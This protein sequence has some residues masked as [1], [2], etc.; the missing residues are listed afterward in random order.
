MYGQGSYFARDAATSLNWT[1]GS[2]LIIV[3]RVLV[4]DSALGTFNCVMPP[5]RDPSNPLGERFDSCVDFLSNPSIFV[6]FEFGQSY[7]AYII[8]FMN[9]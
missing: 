6:T 9:K 7:P 2:Q 1:R 8:H 5:A 4:G 3:A